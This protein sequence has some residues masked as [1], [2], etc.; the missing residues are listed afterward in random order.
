[1]KEVDAATASRVR[2]NGNEMMGEEE[3]G[4]PS[5]TLS[6]SNPPTAIIS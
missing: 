1:M 6:L 3:E 2:N 5:L 4:A